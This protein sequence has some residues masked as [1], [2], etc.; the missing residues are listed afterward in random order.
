MLGLFVMALIPK[1]SFQRFNLETAVSKVT[2]DLRYTQELAQ[3]TNTNCGINFVADGSYTVY[4]G[5]TATPVTN[6][7][8]KQTFIYTFS[9]NFENVTLLNNLQ[10]EFDTIGKPVLG[11]GQTVSIS[12][13]TTTAN[14]LITANT[15]L[16]QRQ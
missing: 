14:L 8:T 3:T 15:G 10:V 4:K 9:D 16:V 12:D 2:E 6:P 13:G 5:S 7:L 11:G 1:D